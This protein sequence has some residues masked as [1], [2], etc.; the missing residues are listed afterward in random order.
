MKQPTTPEEVSALHKL[1]RADPQAYL[2]I[3]NE[4]IEENPNNH[5]AYFSRHFAWMDLGQPQRAL[6]D[7]NKVIELAP[8]PVAFI[9]RGEVYRFLREYE[10]AVVDYAHAEAMDPAEWQDNGFCLLYQADAH[11]HLGN[12]AAAL[13]CCARLPDDFWTPGMNSTPSGGKADIAE[14]LRR[15]AADARRRGV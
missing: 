4:W 13:V 15:I 6:D 5:H 3:V 9:M 7:L 11:A 14:K 8:E 12:E 10:K 1:L 2:R